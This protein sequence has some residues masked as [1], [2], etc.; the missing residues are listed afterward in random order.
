MKNA[1]KKL[2]ANSQKLSQK[3]LK[4]I[5]PSLVIWVW[6]AHISRSTKV[7]TSDNKDYLGLKICHI[8]SS[9]IPYVLHYKPLPN[10]DRSLIERAI[11]KH[12]GRKHIEPKTYWETYQTKTYS[13]QNI[14]CPKHIHTKTYQ[15]Q[16]ILGPKHIGPKY[17]FLGL[18]Q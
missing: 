9:N 17:V 16:N 8:S 12:I 14:L 7:C 11:P 6:G 2:L 4:Q 5:S 13:Y 15:N 18:F 1:Q 10:K 3:F